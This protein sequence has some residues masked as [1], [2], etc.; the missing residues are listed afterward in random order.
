[1][2]AGKRALLCEVQG[3]VSN[4][5]SSGLCQKSTF[6]WSS[7]FFFHSTKVAK[8]NWFTVPVKHHISETDIDMVPLLLHPLTQIS[9]IKHILY[10]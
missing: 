4:M 5:V 8:L 1:M 9:R 2:D 6:L 10:V 7:F 3:N